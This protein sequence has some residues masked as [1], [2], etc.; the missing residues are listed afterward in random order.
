MPRFAAKVTARYLFNSFGKCNKERIYSKGCLKKIIDKTAVKLNMKAA[1]FKYDGSYNSI[2]KAAIEIGLIGEERDS[3]CIIAARE[4]YIIKA[5][6]IDGL[7]TVT[8][9]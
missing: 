1:F 5:L 3:K 2:N 9:A 6:Q 8:I 7:P 4:I